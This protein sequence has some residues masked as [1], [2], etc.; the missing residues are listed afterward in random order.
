MRRK[1]SLL[2]RV[3]HSMNVAS[4]R[5]KTQPLAIEELDANDRPSPRRSFASTAF[6]FTVFHHASM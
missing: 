1:S 5:G 4:G 3:I 2:L 6:Q